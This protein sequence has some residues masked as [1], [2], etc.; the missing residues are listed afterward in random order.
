[1][2]SLPPHTS[3]RLQPLD[4]CF[5][6]P[7]K[8]QY[9]RECDLWVNNHAGQRITIYDL[10]EIFGKAFIR[11]ATMNKALKGFQITGIVPFDTGVFTEEDF[12]PSQV[13]EVPAPPGN[14]HLNQPLLD[15][16][17][18]TATETLD[19]QP[20]LQTRAPEPEPQPSTSSHNPEPNFQH[21][22]DYLSPKPISQRSSKVRSQKSRTQ[23]AEELT[24]SP[25]KN[26]KRA[27]EEHKIRKASLAASKTKNKKMILKG[28]KKVSSKK[29]IFPK[30]TT[31]SCD[32]GYSDNDNVECVYCNG[33][34]LESKSNEG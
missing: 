16:F 12:L 8:A 15:D 18:E 6:G 20:P 26:A 24:G 34:F 25:F 27:E 28:T 4:C 11:T 13:T 5:Y 33:R 3:H 1:M 30:Q 22:L 17:D 2:I 19:L 7:L 14:E 29:F 31:V 10:I 23:H 32:I 9:S 21:I